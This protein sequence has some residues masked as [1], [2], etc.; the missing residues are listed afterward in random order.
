MNKIIF[1]EPRYYEKTEAYQDIN[2][3][4]H[5][6]K[7]VTNYFYKKI[8]KYVD[9]KKNNIYESLIHVNKKYNINWYDMRLIH[10]KKIISYIMN[11]Y[12]ND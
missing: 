8:N 9:I 5:L 4:K 3:D 2:N 1:P 12:K 6:Q 10:K 11:K 7:S